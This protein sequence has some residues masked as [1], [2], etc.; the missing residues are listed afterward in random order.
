VIQEVID[1]PAGV[2]D[3][4]VD[5]TVMA[6]LRFRQGGFIGTSMD[7]VEDEQ[8]YQRRRNRGYY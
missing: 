1:F 3:D 6:L 5:S 8:P 2:H 4:Y 7:E